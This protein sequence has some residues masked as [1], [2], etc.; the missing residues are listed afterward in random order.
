M[1]DAF[2]YKKTIKFIPPKNEAA[3]LPSKDKE[4]VNLKAEKL[5]F[6]NKDL[7]NN[8]VAPKDFA[9]KKG[10]TVKA[11]PS[12][13]ANKLIEVNP[14]SA[15]SLKKKDDETAPLISSLFDAQGNE[16]L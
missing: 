16:H 8:S 9:L 10:P 13:S 7:F 12:E 14:C 15:D 5:M 1:F 11:E 6:V 2:Q 4:P 3:G